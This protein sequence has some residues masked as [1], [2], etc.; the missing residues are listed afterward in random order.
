[1]TYDIKMDQTRESQ[2]PLSFMIVNSTQTIVKNATVVRRGF[3]LGSIL[4]GIP[5]LGGL[6]AYYYVPFSVWIQLIYA[7]A[8]RLF[9]IWTL[10]S[11][12]SLSFK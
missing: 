6:T 8:V 1:M 10:L 3:K 4:S 9:L 5:L 7:Y 2:A 11:W 12:L